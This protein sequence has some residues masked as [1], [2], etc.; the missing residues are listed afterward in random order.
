[1]TQQ[2]ELIE[3]PE[4]LLALVRQSVQHLIEQRP[5]TAEQ[6]AQLRAVAKAIEQ[7]EKQ[8]IPVPDSLRQTKMNLVAEIGQHAQFN[9][10]LMM[11]GEGIAEVLEMIESATGKLRS[12]V[13]SQ[14]NLT[15]RQRR[16]RNSDQPVTSQ[17]VLRGYIIKALKQLSGSARSFDVI[18]QMREVLKDRLTPRDLETRNDGRAIVW[19][20]NARWERQAM[21]NEGILRNDSKFGYWELNK[22]HI[23]FPIVIRTCE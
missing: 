16:S 18:A 20:N 3:N 15:P 7:L 23:V 10:Q 11:L 12:E 21:V 13:K 9:C 14:K 4:A 22:D 6:E 5:D 8:Q 2:Q 17:S 19:E 1:M